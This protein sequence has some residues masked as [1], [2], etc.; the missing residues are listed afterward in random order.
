MASRGALAKGFRL[1]VS[2]WGSLALQSGDSQEFK[3]WVTVSVAPRPE[4]S[5]AKLGI[6]GAVRWGC[7]EEG[8]HIHAPGWLGTERRS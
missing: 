4:D 8:E 2:G 5:E 7:T 3:F 6:V 1:A